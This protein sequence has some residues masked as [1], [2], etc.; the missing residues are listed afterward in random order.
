LDLTSYGGIVSPGFLRYLDQT[1]SY[2]GASYSIW[3]KIKDD[4]EDRFLIGNEI[5]SAQ[6]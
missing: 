6:P 4:H 2:T 5:N 3:E 1:Q